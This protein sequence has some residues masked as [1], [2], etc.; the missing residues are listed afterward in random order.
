M[1]ENLLLVDEDEG[2]RTDS[3]LYSNS[4]IQFRRLL[5]KL[6]AAA[7]TCDATGL[8]TYYN[9]HAIRLWGRAP[10]LNDPVDRFCGSFK[11]F[12]VN[13]LPI[14]HDQCWMALALQNGKEYNGHEILIERPDGTRVAALAHANPYYDEFGALL[15]AVNVLV[16]ITERK[17]ME[18]A[19]READRRKDEFLATL[20]HEL[21]NPLAPIS[22]AVEL[23]NIKAS[24]LPEINRA[25][26]MIGRQ[27]QQ[28]TRLID[29]LLD[30]SRITCN[31][32]ELR[33]ERI[34]LAE[35]LQAAIDTSRPLIEKN[36]QELIVTTP[37]NTIFLEADPVRLAQ[38][39]ANL[40]NNAAKYSNR[41][42][43]INLNV[44]RQRNEVIVTVKDR[45]I[46]ISAEMLPRI[47]DMFTQVD[48]SLT[49]SQGGLGIGLT[50]VKRLLDM[51]G[52]SITAH[53][54]GPGKGSEFIVCL[55]IAAQ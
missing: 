47:F 8:I 14:N 1:G 31:K 13:S 51:H 6:P 16:D 19:L 15:G 44:E 18:V 46:G 10:Q 20:A 7:Y 9:E 42:D 50:L 45:G 32:L 33:R 2:Q 22:N 5:E 53:S 52:G 37:A 3:I 11:L 40:L 17:K 30:L 29:D 27:V 26:S 25:V 41:G 28:M 36:G 55:P 4:Q 39:I 43:Q 21:R 49:R 54:E 12:D 38:A 24:A 34:K 35:V 48:G 23:L